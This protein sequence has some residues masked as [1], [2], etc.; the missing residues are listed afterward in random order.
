[1]MVPKTPFPLLSYGQG[2]NGGPK[3]ALITPEQWAG[4]Q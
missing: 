3:D 1:M 2:H 4:A